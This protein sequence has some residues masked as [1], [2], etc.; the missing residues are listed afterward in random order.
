MYF[1]SHSWKSVKSTLHG[2]SCFHQCITLKVNGHGN[3]DGNN[4]SF[5]P[6]HK[7]TCTN[8]CETR[9][10]LEPELQ[11]DHAGQCLFEHLIA[12]C[13]NSWNGNKCRNPALNTEDFQRKESKE[14]RYCKRST[15][16]SHLI[17]AM[18][19]GNRRNIFRLR[20]TDDSDCFITFLEQFLVSTAH[21]LEK[22]A[23]IFFDFSIKNSWLKAKQTLQV[24]KCCTVPFR[25][26][27]SF[28]A[29][30]VVMF[31]I[32]SMPQ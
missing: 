18:T 1:T 32:W 22:N 21:H 28:D 24:S 11:G 25:Y 30:E 26:T 13:K 29:F 31:S 2:F 3:K 7:A 14:N 17:G 23:S 16:K 5:F 4:E 20:T 15:E 9:E 19:V 8:D 12:G 10:N 27:L 6:H